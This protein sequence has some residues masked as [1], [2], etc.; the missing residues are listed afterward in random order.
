MPELDKL[1]TQ[2]KNDGVEVIAISDEDPVVIKKYLSD[3]AYSFNIAW[4]STSNEL[5]N[6]INTRPVSILVDHG[7]VKDIVIGSR[8]Y[9]FFHDWV[10]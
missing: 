9:G 2:A 5:I 3:H 7:L 6:S 4:F 8:G 1:Y 10:R